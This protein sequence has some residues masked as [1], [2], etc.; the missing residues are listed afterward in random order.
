MEE[1]KNC[2][3]LSQRLSQAEAEVE[4]KVFQNKH[5][6]ERLSHLMDVAGKISGCLRVERIDS[7]DWV[8]V[9]DKETLKSSLSEYRS[10]K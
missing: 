2:Q 6:A 5:L 4:N 7:V 3:S 9:D 8:I 10:I 1:C